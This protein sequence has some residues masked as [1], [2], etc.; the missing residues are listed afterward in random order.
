MSRKAKPETD[1]QRAALYA[2][3]ST[4]A[5][6]D[7][8]S[9]EA[10]L[11]RS[12][13]YCAQRG[14]D[15]VC[16]E[17]E[18]I[19]GVFVLARTKFN[20]LLETAADGKLDV[21]VVD[22]PDRLGRGDAIA[23][24]ELL[25]QMNG[26]RIEYAAPGRDTETLEGLALKATDQLVSGIER[27]NIRRRTMEGKRD[28]ARRGR[29]IASAYRP[30]GYRFL[31]TYDEFGHKQT[32]QLVIDEDEAAVVRQIFECLVGE[33]IT[34]R[35]LAKRLNEQ[36]APTRDRKS[37]WSPQT[38]STLIRSAVYRGEWQYGKS[39][40][41]RIDTVDGVKR[42]R[43]GFRHG[44]ELVTV[45]C[46]PIVTADLWDAAQDQLAENIRKFVKPTKRFYLLR[47]RIVCGRCGHRLRGGGGPRQRGSSGGYYYY[48]CNAKTDLA[49]KCDAKGVSLSLVDNIV[50]E[51]VCEALQHPERLLVGA[52][53]QRKEAERARRLLEGSLAGLEAA[54]QKDQE[55]LQRVFE[56]Y[57]D[58]HAPKSK[59]LEEKA[60]VDNRAEKRA[61]E[62]DDLQARLAEQTP[63]TEDDEAYIMEFSRQIAGRL[64]PGVPVEEKAKLLDVLRVECIYDD[65]TGEF[66]ASGLMGR[67]SLLLSNISRYHGHCALAFS[68]TFRI[69]DG[70]AERLADALFSRVTSAQRSNSI[71][72]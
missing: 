52:A 21:I 61:A 20:A 5:Q 40:K 65:R 2:R 29:I 37:L 64:H 53:D 4:T 16:Q 72:Q 30:Y 47:G 24:L 6:L 44:D 27:Q 13:V 69:V 10:Q 33:G 50:W 70:K 22:I 54:A 63:L 59:Y 43:I 71:L 56:L 23:K 49:H 9:P 39:I 51:F 67:Q 3:V 38:L 8:T 15:V 36:G 60:R 45:P 31:S 58:G 19:S 26:A 25:A 17:I 32:C 57:R 35:S 28:W 48:V 41:K 1:S 34:L 68:A 55:G 12:S 18:D 14:Y 46:P 66:V 42:Q 62:R 11:R 7:N